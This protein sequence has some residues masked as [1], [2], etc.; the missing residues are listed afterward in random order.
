MIPAPAYTHIGTLPVL[1]SATGR[2]GS[3][4]PHCVQNFRV[5]SSV[6]A[7][8]EG[9]VVRTMVWCAYYL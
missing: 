7:P 8:Q 9:Q 4:V 6:I 2:S 5:G 1:S 3:F